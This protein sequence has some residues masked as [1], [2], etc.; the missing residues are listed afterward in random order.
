MLK[1][2]QRRVFLFGLLQESNFGLELVL[3]IFDC[4]LLSLK[5]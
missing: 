3:E 5:L 4:E 1:N 2:C